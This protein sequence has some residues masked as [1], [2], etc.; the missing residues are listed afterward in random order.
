MK[1]D[2]DVLRAVEAR[3]PKNRQAAA[4]VDGVAAII[5][6]PPPSSVVP[7]ELLSER[8]ANVGFAGARPSST[9]YERILGSN[10]LVDEFYLERA[11]VAAKP[12]CRITTRTAALHPTGYA[13]G[14]MV[15][16]RLLL[17]NWHVLK[18]RDS[19][20]NGLAEFD[21]TLSI[22]GEPV[23]SCRFELTPGEFFV[24]DERLDVA[25]VAVR[26]TALDDGIGLARFGYHRLVLDPAK[27]LDN[28]WITIIQHPGGQRRQFA[29]RENQLIATQDEF[30]WYASDTA[31]GSSGAPAFN[32]SFQ[33][34]ALHHSGHAK[35]DGAMYVLRDGRRVASL[36]NVDDSEVAW[37]ANEGVRISTLCTFFVENLDQ[38]NPH[39]QE[40]LAT[41][42]GSGDVM[43]Q[44]MRGGASGPVQ[45]DASASGPQ[46]TS[47][48]AETRAAGGIAIPLTLHVSLSLGNAATF[49]VAAPAA[50]VQAQPSAREPVGEEKLTPPQ[51]DSDYT[52][53]KGYDEKFLGPTVP[54]PEPSDA[55]S[56]AKMDGGSYLIPYE[57]FS[58]AVSKKR[59]LALFTVSNVDYRQET[60]R[61]E[62]GDYSRKG[63]TGLGPNDQEAWVTDP[64]IPEQ[65]QLPDKFYNADGGAFDKG[66]IVRRED[67]C[68]GTSREQIIRANCDTFHTTNCS[69]QVAAFNRS[70]LHG[71]WG[72]LENY[73]QKQAKTE[74]YTLF[75][76]PV[77]DD[78]DWV[79]AGKDD[80]G[81][82]KVKIPRK[83]WKVVV[84]TQGGALQ[85]FAFLLE[86]DLSEI[87]LS[88]E[89]FQVSAAWTPSLVSLEEL[90]TLTDV[91]FPS[92]VK[93]A[94]QH[95]REGGDELVRVTSI[96]RKP[97]KRAAPQQVEPSR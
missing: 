35:R 10:D 73:I 34:V 18:T 12:V 24:S 61:P 69:P 96:K 27:I 70:N 38:K 60:R 59:R 15:S 20:A 36:Q 33:V 17:T 71:I 83:F 79:F 87:P 82:V 19:A 81:N 57:H 21:Y 75:A 46:I 92:Q 8:K 86:Q 45:E 95:S 62:P 28:E 65:Q 72:D 52:N 54:P 50:S 7:R 56:L 90:E 5:A 37:D 74:R 68:W 16:P 63:L 25:L 48:P 40:F 66:H 67:V 93:S 11:L 76:G 29:I 88:E 43:A 58:V 13:T 64:R 97:L 44:A 55:N 53:R 42:K 4:A 41:M 39:V 3:R 9:E 85:A 30:L 23:A 94:D 6:A 91:L 77:L 49:A 32:D 84:A 1:L 22:S 31:P 78:E 47:A 2:P 51:V 14:F 26:P 89:E 80:R